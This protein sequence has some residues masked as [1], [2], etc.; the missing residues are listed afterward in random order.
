MLMWR[1]FPSSPHPIAATS[2]KMNFTSQAPPENGRNCRRHSNRRRCRPPKI[3]RRFATFF[4]QLICCWVSLADLRSCR[5]C[6]EI[7]ARG[8]VH[9]RA[10]RG[11][12]SLFGMRTPVLQGFVAASVFEGLV[13]ALNSHHLGAEQS[14]LLHV[15]TLACHVGC[16]HTNRARHLHQ[17][18]HRGRCN[19]ACCQHRS[20]Q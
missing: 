4:F 18:A 10:E 19:A 12:K 6:H 3:I 5:P 8:V 20:Q 15:R 17:G 2:A 9:G 16:P 1:P 14:H 11:P 7:R 13:S